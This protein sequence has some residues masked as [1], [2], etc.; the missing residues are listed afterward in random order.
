M[1]AIKQQLVSSRAKTYGGK[2]GRKYITIHET[3]NT[4]KGA[5]AQAHANLQS[6]GFSAS[7][8]W[9]VDDKE[10]IQSFPHDVQCWHA[11]DGRGN[12]N[13]NSI[14][15]EICVNSDGNFK[16][17]VENAAALVRKIM[18]DENI[19]I[20]NVVQHNHW[21]GKN[22]PRY[23]RSGTKGITWNDFVSMVKGEPKQQTKT[24]TQKAQVQKWTGQILRKGDSGPL[25]KSLQELLISKG[26]TLPKYGADGKFGSETE[27]AVRAAQRASGITVDGVPGPQTYK[28]LKNY[29]GSS[30]R[31]RHWSGSVIRNG[32]RGKHVKELQDRLLALGYRLPRFGADGVMGSETANAVRKFQRDAGIKVDGIPGPETKKSLEGRG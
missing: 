16:E 8:H 6:N 7:W 27:N 5:N 26:F 30:F 15:I 2:N 3:A 23:L 24:K 32:E 19:S 20:E 11:G 29:D 28:A 10:A 17:A 4:N 31:F 13:L 14:G 12:G 22:C 21:S 1:V 18:Q 25:V 9:T